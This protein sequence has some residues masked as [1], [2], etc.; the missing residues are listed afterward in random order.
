MTFEVSQDVLASLKMGIHDLNK[1]IRLIAAIT[2][3]QEKRLSLG[4]AA[5][6]AGINPLSFMDIVAQKGLMVFD[7]DESMVES[8]LQ[9]AASLSKLV[10]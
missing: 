10:P 1:Q 3:F 5:E 8:E 7:Y 2:Y 6:L 4:K 9:G